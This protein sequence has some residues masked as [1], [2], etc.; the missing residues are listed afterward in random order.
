LG[1]SLPGYPLLHRYLPLLSGLRNVGRWGWLELLSIAVLAGF[2]VAALQKGRKFPSLA[3]A[4]LALLV[5]VEAIR[6]P[7]G[8]T[9]A[10]DIPHLYDR[11]AADSS[12]VLAEFP[13]YSGG[14][15]S[16]NGPYVLANTR[17]F[18][19]LL[20]GYSSFHPE[21]FEARGRALANFPSDRALAELHGLHVTHVTV[22]TRRYSEDALKR[23]DAIAD[24]E[25]VTEE[26]GIRLYQLK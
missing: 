20:N 24:L 5:T 6:T 25:F 10:Y 17:Y 1:T 9:P 19:P 15:V 3:P 21:T 22:H 14:N 12:L 2:G 16:L 11:F 23:I 7:V 18:R 26:D 8:F 4:A 13:F